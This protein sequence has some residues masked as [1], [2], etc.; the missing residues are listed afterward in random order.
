MSNIP[1]SR[2]HDILTLIRQEGSVTVSLLAEQF[3]VSELTIRRDLDHLAKKGLV[4]RTHGGATAGEIFQWN[5][6][7][8][9]KQVNTPPRR[10]RLL[11]RLS[12]PS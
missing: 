1:A 4:E 8:Y 2:Q 3:S 9:R 7:T 5:L 10:K 11:Q 6:I 12:L